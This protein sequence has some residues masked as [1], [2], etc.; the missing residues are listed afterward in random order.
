MAIGI[1]GFKMICR[2]D[3]GEI[4]FLVLTFVACMMAFALF[5]I[6]VLYHAVGFVQRN[7]LDDTPLSREL[8][9]AVG[10]FAA[11][12]ATNATMSNGTPQLS[13]SAISVSVRTYGNPTQSYFGSAAC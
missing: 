5:V 6:A 2:G 8:I 4:M 13:P 10:V 12:F 9:K 1:G 3:F 7:D 11:Q